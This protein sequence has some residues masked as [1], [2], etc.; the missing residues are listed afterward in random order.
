MGRN[1]PFIK[2]GLHGTA[3]WFP[4][5]TYSMER[6]EKRITLQGS[7]LSRGLNVT[8]NSGESSWQN[9]FL[10]R[11]SETGMSPPWASS[12]KHIP[13]LLMRKSPE[14]PAEE[15]LT[16]CLTNTPRTVK[17]FK[18]KKKSEKPSYQE[19]P[20]EAWR[21]S[22][23]WHPGCNLGTEKGY[24]RTSGEIRVKRGF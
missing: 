12:Q 14:T 20:K 21:L 13:S 24:K 22:G 18:N 8:S 2:L 16:K 5:K 10:V 17:V 15:H 4:S 19:E 7:N 1:S 6:R 9:L 11:C 23:T 3:Q